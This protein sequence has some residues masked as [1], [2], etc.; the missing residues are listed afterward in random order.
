MVGIQEFRLLICHRTHTH[1][2]IDIYL[3]IYKY[4][5]NFPVDFHSRILTVTPCFTVHVFT[6]PPSS[7]RHALDE[8]VHLPPAFSETVEPPA[9]RPALWH[10][11]DSAHPPHN[12]DAAFHTIIEELCV[13]PFRESLSGELCKLFVSP[14]A[15][16]TLLYTKLQELFSFQ[17]PTS[18]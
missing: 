10:T 9:R 18:P 16:D 15:A 17:V 13:L 1:I 5:S 2:H 6:L 11:Q 12:F 4:N 3:S 8:P 14:R 7:P